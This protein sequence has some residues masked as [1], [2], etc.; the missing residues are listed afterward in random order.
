[1]FFV[2]NGSNSDRECNDAPMRKALFTP[3]ECENKAMLRYALLD[4]CEKS[5][6]ISTPL[7]FQLTH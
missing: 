2:K 4:A 3:H 7:T 1:M 5:Y 6:A